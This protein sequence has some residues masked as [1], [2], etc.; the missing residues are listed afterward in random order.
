[1]KAATLTN[2]G[3][4]GNNEDSVGFAK[5][6]DMWC[7]AVCDGLG[8][9]SYGEV[10]SKLVCDTICREF[11]NTPKLLGEALEEYLIRAAV[12]LEKESAADEKKWDMS[13]TA[14]VLV[15]DG[16][17][18][19][20][21]N[22]GDS[23][24]YYFTGGKIKEVTQDHSVAFEEF[25][26]GQISYDAIRRS[27][28]QNKLLRC[29]GS[30]DCLEADISEV[31]ELRNGDAFLLCTDGFWEYVNESN[32]ESMLQKSKTPKEWLEKMLVVLHKN[33]I[34]KNDNYSAIAIII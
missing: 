10:A 5:A 7:F 27:K 25:K 2:K 34:E 20:W 3:G 11:K 22:I 32:M 30:P 16:K 9:H 17:K 23:R 24:L 28:N 29:V 4:R 21:A 26:S 33:E 6:G 1:M 18:A 13:S 8:G 14:V 31:F 12:T 15:T 19:V